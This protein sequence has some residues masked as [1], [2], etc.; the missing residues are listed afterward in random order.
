MKKVTEVEWARRWHVWLGL[1]DRHGF[2]PSVREFA[3]AV[4]LSTFGAF[5]TM[6]KF[7]AQ[8]LLSPVFDWKTKR[9]VPVCKEQPNEE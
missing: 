9:Y 7:E 1:Y 2:P 8:G 4:G 5:D 6:R 3:K